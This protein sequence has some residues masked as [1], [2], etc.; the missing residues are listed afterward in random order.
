MIMDAGNERS[1]LARAESDA[2]AAAERALLG[3]TGSTPI[4][5]VSIEPATWPD[6]SMGWPE[7]G[8]SYAQ[9][10]TEGYRITA[11]S[12]GKLFECRVAGD[13]ARCKVIKGG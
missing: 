4:D 3:E 13:R 11:R 2:L 10:L 6:A 5:L 1:A 8:R 7:P 9:M 12:A